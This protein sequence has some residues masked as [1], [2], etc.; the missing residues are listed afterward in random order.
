MNNIAVVV[1]THN[2]AGVIDD[3]LASCTGLDVLVVDNSSR[4][5]T[6][7][8]VEKHLNVRLIANRQNRGFAGAVNQAAMT[9]ESPYILLLNPDVRLR[10]SPAPLASLLDNNPQC[11]IAAGLLA[12]RDG[13][14]QKG[15]TARRFPS[16]TALIF[17]VLG[18]NRV[19]PWNPVNRHYRYLDRNFTAP[20]EVDQPAGA[21]LLFRK[22]L[23]RA[24]GGFDER[25]YPVWF[26]DVDFCR[27][28]VTAGWRI[29]LAPSVRA[30]HA[31]GHSVNQLTPEC[32]EL[33]W[34]GSL[35]SYAARHF[36]AWKFRAI[37]TAVVLGSVLRAIA[38]AAVSR[39][40]RPLAIYSKVV[41]LAAGCMLSGNGCSD[42]AG[43]WRMQTEVN[44]CSGAE[45]GI[46]D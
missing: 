18:I 42:S 25:F 3:C 5:S 15:F 24:M 14:P 44:H 45:T 30:F 34:Y 27:R 35:L 43:R 37:S 10:D 11:G 12:N 17:E 26:E 7:A 32:R 38:G 39:S 21:L 22:E 33:F 16:A 9:I 6:V 1:V 23:W 29:M 46:T 36:P 2:S 8:H 28:A 31:G 20:A 13:S 4:D 40:L 41:R 19:A